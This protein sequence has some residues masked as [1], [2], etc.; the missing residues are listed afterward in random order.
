M[1]ET[2]SI[3][4]N[5]MRKQY[6]IH[7][8]CETNQMSKLSCTCW[9]A[10]LSYKCPCYTRWQQQKWPFQ[11]LFRCPL[12]RNKGY[13]PISVKPAGGEAGHGVGIWHFSKFAVKF[14]AHGQIIPVKCNQISPPWAAHRREMSQGWTQGRHNKNIS[15]IFIYITLLHH[16]RYTFLLQLQLYVLLR[17]SKTC[18][19]W[20]S[21]ANWRLRF[22]LPSIILT[23]LLGNKTLL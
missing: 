22:L 5:Q 4:E 13:A 19:F 1:S 21:K 6:C 7:E 23:D 10:K 11:V 18:E 9:A 20:S 3:K 17:F 14:P 2:S 16:Q 8:V 12:L 15:A